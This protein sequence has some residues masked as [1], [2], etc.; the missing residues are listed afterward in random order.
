M[1]FDKFI[2]KYYDIYTNIGGKTT[3]SESYA[4]L[5]FELSNDTIKQKIIDRCYFLCMYNKNKYNIPCFYTLYFNDIQKQISVT[6]TQHFI[7]IAKM[8]NEHYKKTNVS[9]YLVLAKDI[10]DYLKNNNFIN[11]YLINWVYL[12]NKNKN[13][14]NLSSIKYYAAIDVIYELDNDFFNIIFNTLTFHK[15]NNIIYHIY[16]IKSKEKYNT[17]TNMDSHQCM[18]LVEGLIN[19]YEINKESKFL[20]LSIKIIND[21]INNLLT[22]KSVFSKLQVFYYIKKYNILIN[23]DIILKLTSFIQNIINVYKKNNNIYVYTNNLVQDNIFG[24][25]YLHRLLKNNYIVL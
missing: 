22:D 11:N 20:D 7:W 6:N 12:N 16:D 13:K 21:I 3:I 5:Y 4:M 17:D 19:I 8:F 23:N 9:K 18:E 24:Y 15:K 14:N 25:I 10:I 1:F 2:N